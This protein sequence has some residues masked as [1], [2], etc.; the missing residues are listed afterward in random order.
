[1]KQAFDITMDGVAHCGLLVIERFP[2]DEYGVDVSMAVDEQAEPI[3]HD[4][5]DKL[6]EHVKQNVHTERLH[7]SVPNVLEH[8]SDVCVDEIS[9]QDMLRAALAR[10]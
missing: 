4:G 3:F 6:L 7:L 2:N 10:I 1:M 5:H 8:N 9:A